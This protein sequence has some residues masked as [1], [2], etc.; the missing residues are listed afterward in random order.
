MCHMSHVMCQVSGVTCQV[1]CVF[2]LFFLFF[3]FFYKV[4]ELVVEGLLSTGPTPS[5]LYSLEKHNLVFLVKII[6][7][8]ELLTKI[9]LLFLDKGKK[10]KVFVACYTFQLVIRN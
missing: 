2:F 8:L 10:K 5:S 1:S 3:F 9:R 4:V 7:I 6:N